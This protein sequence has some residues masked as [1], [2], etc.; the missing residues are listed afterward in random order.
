MKHRI[1]LSALLSLICLSSAGRTVTNPVIHGDLP[2]P[3]VICVDRVYY[4]TGTSSEWA[5]HYPIYRSRD[6][7]NWTHVGH[8]FDRKP[9][10]TVSS[11][12][13]P[14]IVAIDGRYYV[15]YTA[16]RASD[17]HS[18]IGVAVADRPEGPYTDCGPIVVHGSEAIDA[19]VFDD[20]DGRRFI[21]WKAYGLDPRPIELMAARLSDDC[22]STVGE[23]FT[24]MRDDEHTLMEGQLMFREGDYYYILYSIR[25]CCGFNSD[26]AVSA[27]R[28]RRLEGPYERCPANPILHGGNDEIKS[29]GHG[30]LVTTPEGERYYLCHAY[31]EGDD[32][33]CGRQPVIYRMEMGD[34]LWPRFV[35]GADARASVDA[36]ARCSVQRGVSDF[37]DGFNS[38]TL[39][40]D[41][42]WNYPYSDVK[43]ACRD[44]RLLLSG[45]PLTATADGAALCVRPG[46][47]TY[48]ISTRPVGR[49]TSTQ[50]LTLYGDENYALIYGLTGR[51][52]MI[53]LR[54][55]GREQVLADIA[56]PVDSPYL[57]IN[58]DGG[59]ARSFEWSD[60]GRR[61]HRIALDGLSDETLRSLNR[62]DRVTRPGL[63]HSGSPI[64]PAAF[65]FFRVEYSPALYD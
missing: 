8:V 37:Y 12:W 57:R 42:S 5:P 47:P 60:D 53:T 7:V 18:Y 43:A 35:G 17:S 63:Y 61:W 52:L 58:V 65:D 16:R 10:W 27:A 6:L 19:Y 14:E 22:L 28:S 13:A 1:V 56:S 15:Y 4:A 23:P 24:L 21:S 51:R 30:T 50:A 41:W 48:S 11:F 36:P 55:D 59:L 34:D 40:V 38:D 20:G 32:F 2:D 26:Y 9:E 31:M 3:S 29:V 64:A 54:A 25:N 46:R 49:T 39:L 62:W 45:R 33:L 44:G